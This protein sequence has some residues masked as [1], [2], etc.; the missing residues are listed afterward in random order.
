MEFSRLEKAVIGTI[1]SQPI[2]GMEVVRTQFAAASVTK[3]DYTSVGFFTEISVPPSVPPMPSSKELHDA[4]FSGAGG[5]P[6][7]DPEG[8]VIF[9]LHTDDEGYISCLEGFTVRDS[10]PSSEDDIEYI[11]L[12]EKRRD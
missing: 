10:W 3:R 9:M 7:S 12:P 6:E 5:Y 1:L 11:T 2:A 8:W 4:L